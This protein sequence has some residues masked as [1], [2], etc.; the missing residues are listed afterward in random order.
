MITLVI[1]KVITEEKEKL[2]DVEEEEEEEEEEEKE[3]EE[4]KEE[5]DTQ[6]IQELIAQLSSNPNKSEEEE[7]KIAGLVKAQNKMFELGVTTKKAIKLV[8]ELWKF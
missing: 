5:E 2:L 6:T 8:P 1:T 3:E 7:A 4:N